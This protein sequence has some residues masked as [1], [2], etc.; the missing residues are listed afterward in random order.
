[1]DIGK[2]V[3]VKVGLILAEIEQLGRGEKRRSLSP[4]PLYINVFLIYFDPYEKSS[5]K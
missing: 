1:L 4:F 2:T 5:R 3:D